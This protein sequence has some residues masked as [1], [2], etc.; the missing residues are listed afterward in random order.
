MYVCAFAFEIA[1]GNE[2]KIEAG[3]CVD[4]LE[5]EECF[6][7]IVVLE[8]ERKVPDALGRSACTVGGNED[9][10]R[11]T[12]VDEVQDDRMHVLGRAGVEDESPSV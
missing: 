8:N 11:R 5:K 1:S 2:R 7:T 3:H 10:V 12:R 9:C 4:F 6:E